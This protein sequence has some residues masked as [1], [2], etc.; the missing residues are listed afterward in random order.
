MGVRWREGELEATHRATQELNAVALPSCWLDTG[1]A[2]WWT[3]VSWLQRMITAR[4]HALHAA[5]CRACGPAGRAG[6]RKGEGK[7]GR[8]GEGERR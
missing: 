2:A 3:S 4:A 6:N 8:G 7:G 1:S 5:G